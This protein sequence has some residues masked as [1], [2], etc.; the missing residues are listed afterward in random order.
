MIDSERIYQ[1]HK[2]FILYD[3]DELVLYQIEGTTEVRFAAASNI[4]KKSKPYKGESMRL[5]DI[6][7]EFIAFDGK[8]I[9][10]LLCG[11]QFRINSNLCK[12]TRNLRP[13]EVFDIFPLFFVFSDLN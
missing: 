7:V 11:R 12:Q 5:P 3:T 9:L 13:G 8:D 2:I 6:S 4:R 1:N 10:F